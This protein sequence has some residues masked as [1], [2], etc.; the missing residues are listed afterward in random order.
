MNVPNSIFT[1]DTST[2]SE[3]AIQAIQEDSAW[4]NVFIDKCV[5]TNNLS[6]SISALRLKGAHLNFTLNNNIFSANEAKNMASGVM[7]NRCTGT[8]FNCLFA[9]NNVDTVGEFYNLGSV[10]VWE[11]ANVDF[12]NCTFTDNSAS[13]GAGLFSWLW[14]NG[15]INKLYFLE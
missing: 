10:V 1:N 13:Y 2:S 15:Y 9:S 14:C 4:V 11:G 5:F 12:M 8:V 7:F 3:G 6:S